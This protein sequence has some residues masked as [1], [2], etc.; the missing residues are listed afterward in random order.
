MNLRTAFSAVGVALLGA[1]T[2]ADDAETPSAPLILSGSGTTNPSKCFWHIM[3]QM[4]A[5]IK[6]VAKLS[7][8]AVGSGTGIKEFLGKDIEYP[9][10]TTISN[11]E[12][13]NDFGAGDIPISAEDKKEWNDK[14]YDFVQ[15]PFVLSAVSFFHSIPGVP[16]GERGLNMTACLLS[17]VFQRDITTWDHPDI[18]NINP[19]LNVAKDYPIYV[20]R[21]VL[22][23]SSTYS[24]TQYLYAQ[25][26][27]QTEDNPNG[28]PVDKVASKIEWH[29]ETHEC[30][31]SGRMASCLRDNGGSIGYLD[32]FDGH[33]E[34][35][36]EIRLM[37]SDGRFL[38]SKEAGIE[39]IQAAATDL[40][41]FPVSADGDFSNVSLMNQPGPN[42][43]PITLVSY[44]YIR[45]NLDFLPSPASRTLLKAF[46]TALF[47][48]TYID[49]C[50]DRYGL[51]A[52]P[53]LPRTMS[54]NGLEMLELDGVAP[55]WIFEK[56]TMPGVG[57]G[58]YVISTRRMGVDNVREI[59]A[60]NNDG[61]D[62]K[63]ATEE[64]T[65]QVS[66]LN[67]RV[68]QLESDL[69]R[70]RDQVAS[71]MANQNAADATN[72]AGASASDGKGGGGEEVMVD[73]D[74]TNNIMPIV[75]ETYDPVD[76]AGE[77]FDEGFTLEA[78]SAECL[79][80]GFG[81]YPSLFLTLLWTL[82]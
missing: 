32:A 37:N 15:L 34:G 79:F 55:E 8:R 74:T 38:T 22:G 53:P 61:V 17:R 57:Q 23:S 27:T 24:I 14:G 2:T 28:W 4:Q 16:S 26:P 80:L 10:G 30:D 70:M 52:V 36:S 81:K 50:A 9:N 60:T 63:D 33:N 11:Y 45:K 25:C 49:Q 12:A 71:I 44:V 41:N 82:V 43:W 56:S 7:Y 68:G 62:A 40:S 20:G 75:N 31:G 6:G 72:N 39:G 21:R 47:D 69:A 48:P 19:G 59:V 77:I 46:A 67:D 5:Q 35:L 76:D 18:L 58:D 29:Q 54:L 78:S 64:L 51:V 3:S 73:T 13:W 66:Y 65:G 1:L 42:T